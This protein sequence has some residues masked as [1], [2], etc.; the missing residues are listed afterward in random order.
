M[1]GF[2]FTNF[3]KPGPG[4]SKDAPEKRRFIVFFE[5]YIR[6][7]WKLIEANLLFVAVCIP[8][9]IPLFL[10]LMSNI[11]IN[12]FYLVGLIPLAGIGP[13]TAGF[14]YILRNFSREQHAFIWMDFRDTFK[15]NW[16]QSGII[17]LINLVVGILIYLAVTTYSHHLSGSRILI[18]PFSLSIT[19]GVI[20]LFMQYYIFIM[21]VTFDLSIATLYKNA[22]I[23]ALLGI[24]RNIL[25]TLICGILILLVYLFKP[26]TFVLIPLILLSTMGLIICF[27]SW[28]LIERY[29]MPKAEE[30]ADAASSVDDGAEEERI[31]DDDPQKK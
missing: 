13:A 6:K 11:P 28:P 16:K 15:S 26:L 7:F 25:T 21:L 27:N 18:I 5:I 20:F 31:F 4:V 17:T 19:A 14:I 23:F 12:Y 29:L 8:F 3:S 1:A 24:G 30:E 2:G 22:A 9:F 10:I